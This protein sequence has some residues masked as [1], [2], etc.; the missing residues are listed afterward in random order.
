MSIPSPSAPGD[1]PGGVP[2]PRTSLDDVPVYRPGRSA[3]GP[4]GVPLAKLSSNELPYPPLPSVVAAIEQAAATANRYP[5]PG[6]VALKSALAVRHGLEPERIVAGTG[7]VAVLYAVLQ[8]FCEPGDDVVYAWRS[9]E[10]YPIAVQLVGARSVRV[11][12]APGAR[13]DVAGLIAA[14]TERTR[15]L[16]ACTPNNPT[17]PAMTQAELTM[18]ADGLPG[19]VLLVIDEAYAEFASTDPAIA[20]RGQALLDRPNVVS[21]RTFSKAYALAGLR[22]GYGVASVPVA[23]AIGKC[24]LPFG[25]SAPAQAGAI[26]ALAAEADVRAQVALVVSERARVLASIRATGLAVPDTQANFV[27]LGVGEST[28]D[29]AHACEA[30][31]CVVRAFAGDGMRASIGAPDDNDRLIAAVTSWNRTA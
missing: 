4:D 7:S 5:D 24:A 9:F 10:A 12:L 14:V 2:R 31:G 30:G 3:V 6:C 22:V 18:L 8:A 16:L 29:L 20:G 15:V 26:A 27:W 25:V 21:L 23:D 1:A 13:H 17:G 28:A 19:H 11:P